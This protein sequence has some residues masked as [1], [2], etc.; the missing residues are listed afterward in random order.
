[1]SSQA[2]FSFAG[3]ETH[4]PDWHWPVVQGLPRPSLQKPPSL[5]GWAWQPLCGSQ[6]PTVHWLS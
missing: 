5:L 3:T 2:P 6:A 4:M 1:L